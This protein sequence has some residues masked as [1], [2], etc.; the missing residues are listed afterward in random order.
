MI[1][2]NR[3]RRGGLGLLGVALAV[4]SAG[5]APRITLNTPTPDL[6]SSILPAAGEPTTLPV[7]GNSTSTP[8]ATADY[9]TAANVVVEPR[10]RPLLEAV[11]IRRGPDTGYE[12]AGTL[13]GN[14]T[15]RVLARDATAT[16][17]NIMT[18]GGLVGWVA[19]NVVEFVSGSLE[20][21]SI[22]TPEPPTSTATSVPPP[23]PAP[24]PPAD[25]PTAGPTNNPLPTA[26]PMAT[27]SLPMTKVPT[28]NPVD[29]PN[30]YP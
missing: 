4:L 28:P 20:M 13:A 14:A 30:P 16:W 19:A 6:P 3:V 21:V 12:I 24:P 29:T 8:A 7:A 23:P 5:C 1:L 27:T 9:A 25:K 10:V 17:L 11:N 15:A 26:T 2:I 18:D 22:A